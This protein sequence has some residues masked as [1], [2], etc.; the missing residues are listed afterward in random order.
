[1]DKGC[2]VHWKEDPSLL[3]C[4][5]QLENTLIFKCFQNYLPFI[6]KRTLEDSEGD[7]GSEAVEVSGKY[8][9]HWMMRVVIIRKPK[10]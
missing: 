2:K 5:L 9:Q 1:M 10:G 4:W 7:V 8:K 3:S 6:R